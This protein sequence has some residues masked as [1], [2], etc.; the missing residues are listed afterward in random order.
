MRRFRF[1]LTSISGFVLMMAAPAAIAGNC[2]TYGT[3][4]C[5]PGVVYNS[6]GAPHFDPLQVNVRQPLQGL[7][8]VN[9]RTAPSVSITR[10]YGQSTLASVGDSP[11][12]FT[13]G[14][15]PT[16][17]QYCRQDVGTPV[18]VSFN[19]PQF[20]APIIAAP[21]PIVSPVITPTVRFG[22]G[23][24]P[25]AA[26]PRQ[27]GENIFT[28]GI[29]HIPT[30]YVDRSPVTAERL[31]SSGL[32]QSYHAG[33]SYIAAPT[34]YSHSSHAHAGV[35]HQSVHTENAVSSVDAS[36]GYW[37]QVSGPT[38]FG[39]TL[40]TQ[41]VCRRQAPV[42]K[43]EVQRVEVQRQIVRPVI[44][45][46]T[47]VPVY[48]EPTEVTNRYGNAVGGFQVPTPQFHG[49]QQP[50]NYGQPQGRWTY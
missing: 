28:P 47:P 17:T 42:Q 8:S 3:Q 13:G 38:L 20:Q 36:G 4:N 29:A 34:S 15:H 32:T 45:V 21:A 37:E 43:V 48:C 1:G 26:V 18:N 16:T 30:S 9:I 50:L 31:L 10:L 25:A 12:G 39:N 22:G 35:S 14:C 7:R 46:P 40:A 5:D 33:S 41:V 11:S 2:G 24:N 19:R 23:Y 44:T 49:V 27:Y 6:A